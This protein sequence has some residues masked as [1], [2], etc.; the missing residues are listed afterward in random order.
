MYFIFDQILSAS[1]VQIFQCINNCLVLMFIPIPVDCLGI[2]LS[3]RGINIPFVR[4]ISHFHFFIDGYLP[5]VIIIFVFQI[6]RVFNIL[7]YLNS[8]HHSHFSASGF[9]FFDNS[10]LRLWDV[11]NSP[12]K[13]QLRVYVSYNGKFGYFQCYGVFHFFEGDS[14]LAT[15]F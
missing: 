3:V 2:N 9:N 11:L 7:W 14:I 4:N 5:V 1:R 8:K 13:C 6:K 15:V 10:F 12:S